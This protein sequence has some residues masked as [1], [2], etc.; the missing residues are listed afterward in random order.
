MSAVVA[1]DPRVADLLPPGERG[2]LA[3]RG[4]PEPVEV[5]RIRAV[6]ARPV[7]DPGIAVESLAHRPGGT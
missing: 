6:Q 5:V 7:G 2:T 1:D 3:L 4:I